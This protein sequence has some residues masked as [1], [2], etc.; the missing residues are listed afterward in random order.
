M[1]N[2]HSTPITVRGEA[3]EEFLKENKHKTIILCYND[4]CD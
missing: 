2:S 3:I 1:D 4:F